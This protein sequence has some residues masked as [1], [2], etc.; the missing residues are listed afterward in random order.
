MTF[1]VVNVPTKETATPAPDGVTTDFSVT[2]AYN[3]RSVSV[4]HNGIKLEPDLDDGFT[5]LGGSTFR[6]KIAPLTED[7]IQAEY[8]PA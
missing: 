3:P 1:Q 2:A 6:M 5:E 7:T 8:D 4:W